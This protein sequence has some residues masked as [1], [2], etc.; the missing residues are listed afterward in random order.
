VFIDH[1]PD[2]AVLIYL[3]I[4][5]RKKCILICI[6]DLSE[7]TYPYY[8]S[9]YLG[10]KVSIGVNRKKTKKICKPFR[11]QVILLFLSSDNEQNFKS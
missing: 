5:Y 8:L 11:S 10:N 4:R 3:R 9:M 2:G 6:S 1:L 7:E